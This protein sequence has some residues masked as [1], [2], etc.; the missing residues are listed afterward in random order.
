MY[1][2]EHG[3]SGSG[4]HFSRSS[5]TL[6]DNVEPLAQE[7]DTSHKRQRCLLLAQY[8]NGEPIYAVTDDEVPRDQASWSCASSL[9]LG[10]KD[11]THGQTTLARNAPKYRDVEYL[12]TVKPAI[13]LR[14]RGALED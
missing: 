1:R 7:P 14:T 3:R 4:R 8:R 13:T 9:R 5:R 11:R 12:R 6:H 10:F 2:L